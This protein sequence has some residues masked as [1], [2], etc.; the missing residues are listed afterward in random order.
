MKHKKSFLICV[1]FSL[2]FHA[3]AIGC[4]QKYSLWFFSPG[5]PQTPALTLIDK[6][7]VLQTTFET[8]LEKAA[9]STSKPTVE[10]PMIAV[11]SSVAIQEPENT[12]PFKSSFAIPSPEFLSPLSSS[13]HRPPL[14]TFNLLE[15]L[16]KELIVPISSK[17]A[18]PPHFPI[19]VASKITFAEELPKEELEE[20][21]VA[22]ESFKKIE[23]PISL[24]QKVGKAPLLATLPNLPKLPTLKELET[25]SYSDSFDAELTFFMKETGGYVF[26]ITLI[27]RPD[28]E[29]PR[30]RH[31]LTFLID[32]SN[33]IQQGRLSATKGAIHKALEELHSDDT[34]NIIAFDSKMEKMAPSNLSCS[35]KSF[36]IAEEFLEKIQLG[37]FFS[38]GDLYKPLVITVPGQV[39]SDEIHTAILFTDGES[40]AK[41]NSYRSVLQDWTQYNQGKVALY[42]LAVNGDGHLS[43]LDAATAFNRGKLMNAP[44]NRSLKRKL[45]KLLKMIQN[46][47]GKNISCTAITRKS[48]AKVS[49]LPKSNPLPHLYLDQPYV[50]LGETESLDDFILFIQGRLKD[51]WLN[52]R[53]TISFLNAKK[54]G[55]ELKEEWALHLAYEQYQNYL[56]DNNP[57]HLAEAE[58]LLEPFNY[59]PAFR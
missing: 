40:F 55:K 2:L 43:T 4:L 12:I 30:L 6:N 24:P 31:H 39:A 48:N 46:P 1:S 54:G 42:A 9:K 33:S 17:R 14:Q 49:L 45:L 53:K 15:H 56:L 10:S 32:R 21:K 20:P 18:A 58:T 8:I 47:V 28:L 23:E 59:P 44:T 5:S 13:F 25:S 52:I 51:K 27:P 11:R 34:F 7:E 57:K 16:P 19:P 38:T 26:A 3:L 37:S 35:G 29:L 41:K 50:I 22:I 36:A